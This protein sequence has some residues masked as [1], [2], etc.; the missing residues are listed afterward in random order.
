MSAPNGIAEKKLRITR[1][2]YM[3]CFWMRESVVDGV[4]IFSL[5]SWLQHPCA[6]LNC[7]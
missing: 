7:P 6:Q 3:L 5:I 2:V 4:G 1:T